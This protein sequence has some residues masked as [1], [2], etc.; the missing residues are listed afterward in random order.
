[1]EPLLI[2][3][4]F[5]NNTYDVVDF[6]SFFGDR[7]LKYSLKDCVFAT[8]A[9]LSLWHISDGMSLMLTLYAYPLQPVLINQHCS[10]YK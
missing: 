1:M 10:E 5:K 2:F 8:L 9:A 3:K 6:D 4:V 7:T